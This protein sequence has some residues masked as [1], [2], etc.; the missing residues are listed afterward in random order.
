MGW[1]D[2]PDPD[3]TP[4]LERTTRPWTRKGVPVP[5]VIA[6]MMFRPRALRAVMQMNEAVTFGGSGLGRRAEELIATS[7]SAWNG[8]YY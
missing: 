6:P 1:L 7:V 3:A 2:L 8:C 4:E 5:S